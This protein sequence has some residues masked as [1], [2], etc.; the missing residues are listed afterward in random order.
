MKLTYIEEAYDQIELI[1]FPLISYFDLI[2]DVFQN[3]IKA[4]ELKNHINKKVLLYE[5]LVN[6]R[7]HKGSNDKLIR[8]CTF[9]DQNGDYFDTVHFSIVIEKYPINGIGV[10]ECY[11][12]VSEEF[13]FC[14]LDIIW[15]KKMRLKPDPRAQ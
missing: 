2:D 3:S 13:D 11:G 10:Y 4:N 14:S 9:V 1:G 7:F 6:T 5:V 15:S 8:F 12:C